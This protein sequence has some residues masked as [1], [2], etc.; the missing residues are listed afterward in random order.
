M[1]TLV[2]LFA[3]WVLAAAPFGDVEVTNIQCVG[4]QGEKCTAVR[5]E[6]GEDAYVWNEERI[7]QEIEDTETSC[8]KVSVPSWI[9]G[10]R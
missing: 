4:Y 9:Y 1:L 7:L 3:W 10:A 2:E 8:E 6:V 5:F